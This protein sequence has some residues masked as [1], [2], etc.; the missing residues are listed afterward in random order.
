MSGS[1]PIALITGLGREI[2]IAAGIADRLARDGWDLAFV[3]NAAY[4]ESVNGGAG[5]V[6]RIEAD[7]RAAGARTVAV[8]ADLASADIATAIFDAAEQLG[9]VQALVM[10]H[11]HSTN[12]GILSENVESFDRH[13][14]VNTRASWLLIR[15]F[16]L[17][18]SSAPG[19]GRIVALTSDA[20]IGEIAY[21]AS[22]AALDRIVLAASR[23]FGS[24]GITANLINPGPV[25]TGWMTQE[26]RDWVLDR[27]P[28]GRGG[29]PSDIASLV[30]FLLSSEGG[31]I[32][33]QLL[34]S[35]GGFSALR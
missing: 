32:D 24:M 35:D 14:A 6:A 34:K 7:L 25:D 16:A 26:V 19:T 18:F 3:Y 33:G 29:K 1:R 22:K 15:E 5:D 4:D 12:A 31:W 21:G 27:T 17:R 2:G 11:A 13:F 30:S 23:E 9:P 20:V 10:S 28:A 8:D